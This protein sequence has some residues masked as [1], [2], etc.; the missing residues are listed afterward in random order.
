VLAYQSSVDLET[1]V[2]TAGNAGRGGN[3][4]A[5]QIGQGG[6]IKGNGF[7]DACAGGKG[8]NGGNGGPGGGGAGGLSAGVVWYGTAPTLNG[9]S[10]P[11][12]A[13]LSN[14]TLGSAGVAGTGGSGVS[15]SSTGNDCGLPGQAGAVIAFP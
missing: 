14:V 5:G 8:G 15:C 1:F 6:G 13:T 12:A 2:L 9:T 3:G 4:A 10:T 11:M 7:G